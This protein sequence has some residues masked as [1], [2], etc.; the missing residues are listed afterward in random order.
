MRRFVLFPEKLYRDNEYYVPPLV[1]GEMATLD[2]RV[3]PASEFCDYA[4]FLAYKDGEIVGRIAAIVNRLANSQWNHKEVR[5]GWIDFTDDREVSAALLGKVEE[6]GRERGM[7]SVVGPLGFTDFDPEGMLVEGYDKLGTMPLIYNHPY[8]REHIEALGFVK[9]VDWV[10]FKLFVSEK[11]PERLLKVAELVG[12][13]TN[14]H[15]RKCTRRMF[16]KEDYGRKIFDLINL[17]YKDL[18]EFTV[19]PR[20]MADKYLGFYLNLIDLDYVSVVENDK[21]ELVA[22]G[23]TMPSL[24]RALQKCRGRL[25]P[26]GWWHL[27]KAMYGKGNE[28]MEML[29]IGVR[30]DY[31]NLGINSLLFADMYGKRLKGGCKWAETNANLETNYKIMSQW[32]EFDREL[33]KRRR[34]Y[35]K[36]L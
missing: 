27:L 4:L 12:R 34:S 26:F 24:A 14:V 22:F 6:F 35:K 7:E 9:D 15:L 28:G 19:L 18:Y 13:R 3:N 1:A 20:K 8:Y 36:L 5:F 30:P 31:Q 17:C 16:R 23:I 10:E 11:G 21:G 32:E 2:S 29:L 25:F 33:V